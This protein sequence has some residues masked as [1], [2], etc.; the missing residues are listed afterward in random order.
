MLYPLF[1]HNIGSL[2][3]HPTNQARQS[4]SSAAAAMAA[5]RP[6][7]PG[8]QPQ[9]QQP[10]SQQ[11]QQSQEYM[12]TPQAAPAPALTHHHSMT[13]P[14]SNI[15]QQMSHPI[16]PHVG[17]TSNSYEYASSAPHGGNMSSGM[18]CIL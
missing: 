15:N 4:I 8:Q 10:G 7:Q 18:S 16:A 12:R 17:S 9:G 3:Y 5:R 6:D 1:V 14:V 11:P 2:L 13:T